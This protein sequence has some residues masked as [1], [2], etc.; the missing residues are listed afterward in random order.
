MAPSFVYLFYRQVRRDVEVQTLCLINQTLAYGSLL[1]YLQLTY[2]LKVL[3]NAFPS[4]ES[5]GKY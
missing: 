2:V 4:E 1:D 3:K 5:S